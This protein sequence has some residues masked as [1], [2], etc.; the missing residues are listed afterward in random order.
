MSYSKS[1][2]LK[3]WLCSIAAV[4][5]CSIGVASAAPDF[6]AQVAKVAVNGDI[7]LLTDRLVDEFQDGTPVAE[8]FVDIS[9][10]FLRLVRKGYKFNGDCI[11]EVAS[12]YDINRIPVSVG[13]TV[14]GQSLFVFEATMINVMACTDDGC[15]DLK[16]VVGVGYPPLE[17]ARCDRTE[18]SGNKC[19]CHLDDGNETT[20]TNGDFCN[21]WLEERILS[22]QHWVLPQFI[23]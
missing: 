8:S 3:K 12:I 22:I 18:L 6:R 13:N 4:W 14:A 15:R 21:S 2:H 19:K 17:S 7:V 5:L 16:W 23:Q 20:V 9:N 10:G 11:R 1:F